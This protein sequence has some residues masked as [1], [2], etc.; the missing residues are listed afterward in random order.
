[1]DVVILDLN[2]STDEGIFN[3]EKSSKQLRD[4]FKSTCGA[5]MLPYKVSSNCLILSLAD[6]YSLVVKTS[7][8]R[9]ASLWDFNFDFRN[10][11]SRLIFEEFSNSYKRIITGNITQKNISEVEVQEVLI[12]NG[13]NKRVLTPEQMRD[14]RKLYSLPHGANFSV[15][16]AGKTTVTLALNILLADSVEQMLIV[17]PKSAFQ[18]WD[19]V[20]GECIQNPSIV[21]RFQRV[22]GDARTIR[23]ILDN[24]KFRRF[25]INYELASVNFAE[26]RRFLDMN[27]GKVHL[28]FD[29]SHRIK[30]GVGSL[31]G[32]LALSL[33]NL[34]GRRDILSGTPMPQGAFDIASQ[35]DF[36]FP[37]HGLG[38]RIRNGESPSDVMR[39]LFVR[40]RKSELKLP[41]YEVVTERVDMAPTQAAIYSILCNS[42]IA[43][44]N[45][46]GRANRISDLAKARV[47]RLLQASAF[48][49][50]LGSVRHLF[51]ELFDAA[52]DDGPTPKMRRAYDIAFENAQKGRKT[53]IWTVFT[54]T[55]LELQRMCS[56]LGAEVLFGGNPR[57]STEESSSR[58]VVL[59]KFTSDPTCMVLVANAA[60]ASEGFSLHRVCHEAIYVD[61]TYNAAQYL[62][63][64]DR[65][66]RLGLSADTR[67]RIT[68]LKSNIPQGVNAGVP[69]SI[70]DS[71]WRRLQFK[72][73][74]L[75]RLLDDR[76]LAEIAYSEDDAM[77][78]D[79]SDMDE[80]DVIDLI[81]ELTGKSGRN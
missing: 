15:P 37:A 74:N 70:D 1:M 11:Q 34:A 12:K 61:R 28:V 24:P 8:K 69:G 77:P 22:T 72:V 43:Q 78:S 81:L 49:K 65:I 40:T 45:F 26:L 10:Y 6:A 30:A 58:D 52:M 63:S 47:I 25:Y 68:I 13:F 39:N 41:P 33:A 2:K 59:E 55:L 75:S 5:S 7:S 51:P 71:V 4:N 35:A 16:G 14:V 56:G 66:H 36:L 42:T 9:S 67:T 48:P 23:S 38:T 62:Q 64:L 21:E 18:A 73:D 76:D 29:E 44:F 50:T 53:V 20:V 3:F 27:I 80:D 54:D 17:C 32:Q 57:V 79:F 46:Q 19:D 60:A 31:R